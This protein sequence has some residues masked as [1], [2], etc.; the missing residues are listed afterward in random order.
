MALPE[1][2]YGP[3]PVASAALRVRLEVVYDSP[4]VR[5]LHDFIT[6]DEASHLIRL[7]E[8]LYHRSGTA[9]AGSDAQRTSYSAS[10]PS[11]E[12]VVRSIRDRIA[13]F[14][15]YPEPNLEP[16]QTV[17]YHS[18]QFYK[19][20]HDYYNACETWH[21]GNRHFTFLIYLN[22]VEEGGETARPVTRISM[23]IAHLCG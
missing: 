1:H 8:P 5:I 18:G 16:L 10:L 3:D 2:V 19:P 22:D 7:S 15:G 4:R 23:P 11:H 12:P 20:H 21:Q 14:S 6:P 13:Y 17:R 9:R